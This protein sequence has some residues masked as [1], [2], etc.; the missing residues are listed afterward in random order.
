MILSLSNQAY[1]FLTT[2]AVGFFIG[3]VYDVFRIFRL[4]IKHSGIAIQIED[5]VYW[6]FVIFVMFLFMLHKNYGEIRF[7]SI[8]GALLGMTLYFLTLS[9]LIMKVSDAII[10]VIKYVVLLF[11]NII[12]TPF[13]IIIYILRKPVETT[14][15]FFKNKYKKLLHLCKTYAKINAKK[16]H[17]EM[18]V[19]VKKK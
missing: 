3:F 2:V 14:G 18:S 15:K 7:F 19:I 8:C 17:R 13:K 10:K 4:I 5:V 6:V 1:L 12:F 11:L 16:L 9:K